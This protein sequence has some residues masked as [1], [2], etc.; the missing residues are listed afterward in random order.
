M[1]DTRRLGP[2]VTQLQ[3]FSVINGQVLDGD[4]EGK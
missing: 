4:L 1:S 2:I 3:P